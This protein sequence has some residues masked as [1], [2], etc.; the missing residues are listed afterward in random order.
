MSYIRDMYGSRSEDFVRGFLAAIDTFA[1]WKDGKR[2]IGSPEK[3]A[4]LEMKRA[5]EELGHPDF[6]L[7]DV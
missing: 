1:I 4:K 2:W 7:R 6:D 3:E 5:A